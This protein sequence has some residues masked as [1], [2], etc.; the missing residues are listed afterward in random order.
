MRILTRKQALEITGKEFTK[1]SFFNII[2]DAEMERV[3]SE[4]EVQQC[5]NELKWV[6]DLP[7]KEFKPVVVNT[8]L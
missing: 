5:D 8:K 6:K 4:E 3:I 7:Y 1:D 2:L